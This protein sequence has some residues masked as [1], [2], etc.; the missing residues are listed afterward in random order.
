VSGQPVAIAKRIVARTASMFGVQF[1]FPMAISLP[2]RKGC[3]F[4]NV[5]ALECL[6]GLRGLILEAYAKVGIMLIIY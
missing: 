2:G 5:R 6:Q 3:Y 4:M 1:Y